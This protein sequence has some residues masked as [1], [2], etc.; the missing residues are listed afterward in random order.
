MRRYRLKRHQSLA[1]I[2]SHPPPH[3][4]CKR[5][6]VGRLFPAFGGAHTKGTCKQVSL[7]FNS[8]CVPKAWRCSFANGIG[9][10]EKIRIARMRRNK[11]AIWPCSR[12]RTRWN[13]SNACYAWTV[14]NDD[15]R[16]V[17]DLFMT[18]CV[19]TQ[20]HPVLNRGIGLVTIRAH[21]APNSTWPTS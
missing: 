20:V 4:L 2:R 6:R 14:S 16:L 3:S 13:A 10:V 9:Y 15:P 21:Q 7:F 1:S 8:T 18:Y 12:G 19:S 11:A 5:S 17:M